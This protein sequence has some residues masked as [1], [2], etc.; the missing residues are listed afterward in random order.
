M[1]RLLKISSVALLLA[2]SAAPAFADDESKASDTSSQTSSEASSSE[3]SSSESSSSMESS[4]SSSELSSSSSSSSAEDTGRSI[5]YGQIISAIQAGKSADVS[6]ITEGSTINFVLLSDVKTH[7]KT[8]ALQNALK[9][10]S[11]EAST[12]RAS[13][14]ANATLMA[15]LQAA[16]YTSDQVVAVVLNADGSFT[17]V[18]DDQM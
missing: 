3:A 6:A 8:T 12:L 1:N 18:I 10:N 7:G 16:G 5:N 9:K 15:Q 17:V 14:E 11:G 2:A 13:V 4:S